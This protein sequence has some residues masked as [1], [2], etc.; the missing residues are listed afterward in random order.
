MNRSEL[1]LPIREDS[2]SGDMIR[3]ENIYREIQSLRNATDFQVPDYKKLETTCIDTLKNV[4]KDLHVVAIL[5]EAWANVY[6]LSGLTEGLQLV[7]DMCETFWSTLH[8]N[9]L[10]DQDARLGS[11]VWINDKLSDVLL[12][13]RITAPKMPGMPIYTLATL[14][15]ARQLELVMQKS[16]L[17]KAEILDQAVKENRPT[18]GLITKSMIFTPIE[19]YEQLVADLKSTVAAIERLEGF[20]DDKFKEE[21]ITLKRFDTYLDY[22]KAYASEAL[23]KKRALPPIEQVEL[24]QDDEQQSDNNSAADDTICL[25]ADQLYALLAKIAARLEEIEPKSPAPK[26]VRKAIEW[27]NMSTTELFNDLA[28]N[29]ISIAEITKLLG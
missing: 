19:F 14:I 12:K 17:R 13:T 21:A 2:P 4:S 28:R 26:L 10:D 29:D 3:Y 25:P 23:E 18:L 8:P 7:I 1:L 16:G 11:F 20:L 15:D 9:K 22:I 6:G 5:T 24:S 27:G